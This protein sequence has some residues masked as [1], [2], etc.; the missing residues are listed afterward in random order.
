MIITKVHLVLGTIKVHSEI[1][2]QVLRERAIGMR[3]AGMSTRAVVREWNVNFSTISGLNVV[4]E[5]LATG[6]TSTDQV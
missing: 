4:L 6:L 1:C 2:S 3:T 5:N